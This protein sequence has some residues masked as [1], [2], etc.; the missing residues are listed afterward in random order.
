MTS[1]SDGDSRLPDADLRVDFGQPAP[2]SSNPM[3][4]EVR[5]AYEER[6]RSGAEG[7]AFVQHFCAACG[8][9]GCP[10]EIRRALDELREVL[11]ALPSRMTEPRICFD[12]MC[13]G[14]HHTSFCGQIREWRR[15]HLATVE[16]ALSR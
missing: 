14:G 4:P 16:R 3:P 7:S 6:I 13:G 10:T 11:A 8:S 2:G 15:Q 9:I 1:L 5:A 12:S